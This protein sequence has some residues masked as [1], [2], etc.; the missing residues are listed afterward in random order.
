[1]KKIIFIFIF[2]FIFISIFYN[3][4]YAY[5]VEDKLKSIIVGKI[6]KFIN[7]ENSDSNEFIIT[8][9]KNQL[10][11]YFNSIHKGKKINDKKI[12]IKYINNIENLKFTN[13]LYISKAT[14]SELSSILNYIHEKNILTIS[15][16]RGFAQKGGI[17]QIYS[18][19]QKLKLNINL[20]KAKKENIKIK[21]SLLRMANI[22]E[23]GRP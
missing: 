18:L 4:L 6:A 10:G 15:D 22:V 3:N 11:N 17:I 20:K 19:S 14:S 23:G 12:R 16:L 9:Y 7:W 13:I 5:E 8:V 21:A 2:I 1:M